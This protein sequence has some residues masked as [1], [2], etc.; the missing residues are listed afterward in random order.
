MVNM[1]K[2]LTILDLCM[3]LLL[4]LPK[5]KYVAVVVISTYTER[6]SERRGIVETKLL[7]GKE[8]LFDHFVATHPRGDVLQTT[9]W[10]KLKQGSGWTYYP[11]GAMEEGELKGTSLILTKELPLG[12]TLG[13]SP[14]GPLYTSEKALDALLAAG[15]ALLRKERAVVWKMDPAI[16]Q[17]DQQWDQVARENQLRAVDTGLDFQG[18]QPQHVMALRLDH[19][20]D[21]LLKEMKSKT[22][23]NIRYAER[24]GVQVSLV[25]EKRLLGVFYCLLQETAL[26][27]RF[28][29]RPLSYYEAIWDHLVEHKLA[30]FFL[31][32][33]QK[34]P[35]AGAICFRLPHRVWYVYGASS[36][37]QR[38]LQAAH[39]LQWEMIKWAKSLGCGVYDFRG[40]SGDRNENNP[41]YGL[42]RF[43][44]G[45]GAKL[46]TYVGEY[47][48]PIQRG[49]YIL[50]RAGLALHNRMRSRF[51][52]GSR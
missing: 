1:A 32:Y 38:N 17:G 8:E 20:V 14:R 10:G 41:L 27:D 19:S 52:A 49:G 18:V 30:Q 29:I 36:N 22:R 45:F 4:S 34:T 31:A 24:K 21:T 48:L 15:V 28:M 2:G 25:K 47:D 13:Y 37:E 44:E 43:K 5:N 11:L 6:G 7:W 12:R 51:R 35:L 9:Q 39:L 16:L 33:Y 23:Y 40:V 46:E 50:W 42:Y 26:R 3:R